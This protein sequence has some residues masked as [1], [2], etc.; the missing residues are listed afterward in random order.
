MKR[1]RIV[2]EYK[3]SEWKLVKNIKGKEERAHKATGTKERKCE[4]N[5]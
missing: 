1:Q 2:P 3:W 4:K 5:E